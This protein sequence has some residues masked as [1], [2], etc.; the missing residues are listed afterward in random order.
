VPFNL[1]AHCRR[2]FS[3]LDIK[4][5]HLMGR[6]CPIRPLKVNIIHITNA[7]MPCLC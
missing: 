6:H 4:D 2:L 1:N 7:G 5:V 3:L